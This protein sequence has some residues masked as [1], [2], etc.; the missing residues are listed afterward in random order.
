MS[1]EDKVPRQGTEPE[2]QLWDILKEM[3]A[4]G[5]IQGFDY[6]TDIYTPFRDWPIQADSIVDDVL[7]IEVQGEYWHSKKT[8]HK[9]DQHKLEAFEAMG[10]GCLWLYDDELNKATIPKY[11]AQWRPCIKTWISSMLAY[12]HTVRKLFLDYKSNQIAVPMETHPDLGTVSL[13]G[14][15]RRL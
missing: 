10:Y 6:N 14:E 13:R 15:E 8:R 11:R 12:S 7:V 5:S 3:K 2:E 4:E 9:K 1:W